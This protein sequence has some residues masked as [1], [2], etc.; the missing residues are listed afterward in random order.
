MYQRRCW[1]RLFG[2]GDHISLVVDLEEQWTETQ[3]EQ[4]RRDKLYV[5]SIPVQTTAVKG[6]WTIVF[7]LLLPQEDDQHLETA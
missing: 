7:E 4:G 2:A 1:D 3:T 5:H 6:K